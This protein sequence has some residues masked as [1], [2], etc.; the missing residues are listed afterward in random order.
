MNCVFIGAHKSSIHV[1]FNAELL[2]QGFG[3]ALNQGV[4]SGRL[5]DVNVVILQVFGRTGEILVLI[6]I[7]IDRLIDFY[8][9]CGLP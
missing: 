6:S 4:V 2:L 8:L 1:S 5:V 3:V 7:Q 9:G